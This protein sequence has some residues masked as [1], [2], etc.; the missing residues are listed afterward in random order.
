V[1]RRSPC[2]ITNPHPPPSIHWQVSWFLAPTVALARQ[3]KDV[4]QTNIPVSVGLISGKDEPDQWKDRALWLR[5]LETCRIV[6]STPDVLLNALRHGY[7]Q[8]GFDVGLLVFDEA[9]HAADKHSYNLVMREF[10]DRLPLRPKSPTNVD[11]AMRPAILGLTASPIFGGDA[12]K[13]FRW[14]K[15]IFLVFRSLSGTSY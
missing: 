9:H 14:V 12:E 3:Q 8:L 13:S 6:V 11:G 7:V 2:I 15:S 1:R 5:V 10:Y 4:I